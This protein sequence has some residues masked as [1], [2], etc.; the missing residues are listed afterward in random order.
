MTLVLVSLLPTYLAPRWPG[1]GRAM[2]IALVAFAALCG[3]R[4]LLL[5]A[6][7]GSIFLPPND[8]T[9]QA[10]A[11][12]LR[13]RTEPHDKI[14]VWGFAP[15]IYVLSDRFH[16]FREEGLLS[17]AGANF[18]STSAS[19]QALVPG[20]VREFDEFM[21]DR[22]P[23]VIVIYNV[24]REPCPGQ[25]VI[26]RNFDYQRN[27][28]LVRLRDAIASSY[29]SELIVKGTCDRAELFVLGREP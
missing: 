23:K 21:T 13:S 5:W 12:F 20:M 14:L 19:D 27:A 16:T 10:A 8:S 15:G 3:L 22:P 11:D 6:G 9:I 1:I 25:G 28:A 17:V 26:Q 7:A 24:T 18:T 2:T 29:R 4:P